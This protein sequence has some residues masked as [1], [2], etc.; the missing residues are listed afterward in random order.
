MSCFILFVLIIRRAITA[1]EVYIASGYPRQSTISPSDLLVAVCVSTGD[2]KFLSKNI[3]LNVIVENQANISNTLDK[4]IT[5][6][7]R[8]YELFTS[9]PPDSTVTSGK[10]KFLYVFFGAFGGAVVIVALC[11]CVTCW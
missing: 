3:L 2:N 10:T 6:V 1:E 8:L 11:I 7:S 4:T 5:D 9:S